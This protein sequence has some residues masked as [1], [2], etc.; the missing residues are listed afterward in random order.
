M[1]FYSYFWFKK[2]QNNT[3]KT[4]KLEI[5][6]PHNFTRKCEQKQMVLEKKGGKIDINVKQKYTKSN[7]I[8]IKN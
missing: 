5:A 1:M 7:D 3:Q 2:S 4:H 6:L 8:K